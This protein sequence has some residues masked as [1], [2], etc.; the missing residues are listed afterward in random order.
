MIMKQFLYLLLLCCVSCSE[1]ISS[2]KLSVILEEAG[3]NAKELEIVL[4]H[5]SSDVKDSLKYKSAIYLIENM[6]NRYS[7][8]L[9]PD[10]MECYKRIEFVMDSV[11]GE[12]R[13][14]RD[15]VYN[16]AINEFHTVTPQRVEDIKIITSQY[17][18]DNIEHSFEVWENQKWAQHLRFEEFCELILPYKIFEGQVL[19]DWKS[20]YYKRYNS[21]LE[22]LDYASVFSRSSY[23]ACEIVNQALNRDLKPKIVFHGNPQI[24]SLKTLL[25]VP[26]GTCDE[27]SFLALAAMR[28]NGIPVGMDFTPQWPTRNMGHVWNFLHDNQKNDVVFEGAS[29]TIQVHHK[30]EQ[31]MSKVF[32]N[33]YMINEELQKL[34]E[35]EKFVPELFSK[36][37]IDD[38]T[39]QYMSTIDVECDVNTHNQYVYLTTFDNADWVIVAWGKNK[40]G[41]AFFQNVGK[42]VL[43]MPVIYTEMGVRPVGEPFIA[44]LDG[45]V[46]SIKPDTLGKQ[47]LKLGRKFPLLR[48]DAFKMNMRKI[49]AKIQAANEPNFGNSITFHVFTNLEKEV[50][51]NP[52]F[53][54]YRYWRVLSSSS[55]HSN[56]AE[57]QFFAENGLP[58]R[59]EIIGT[60]GSYKDIPDRKKE[61]AFDGDILT[62][63]D[64][65]QKSGGWIG[66]D[67]QKPVTV[68]RVTCVMRGDGNDVE[69]GNEYELLYWL[70]N[71]WVSIGTKVA[72]DVFLT[73]NGCPRNALFLLRNRSKGKEERIFTYEQGKQIWW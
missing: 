16:L 7:A 39:A 19:D 67:F 38:V 37:F 32:R 42:D 21:L 3:E 4:R 48:A 68:T 29:K 26:Y 31:I 20:F 6:P 22:N 24:A 8:V 63:F 66:M 61:A 47:T 36:P 34:I 15:S 55:G 9:T 72:E 27:Y 53:E 14:I 73:F 57:L 12:P 11:K 62:Y 40:K 69:I 58:L 46:I 23:I 64:A 1:K 50:V 13:E 2:S 28:A 41:K 60:E 65:P 10:I 18:I 71:K 17:L 49:G 43:Y 56:V 54:K 70:D 51:I 52:D 5:Y 30:K 33:K 59:G 25:K 35:S 45:Q 44:T